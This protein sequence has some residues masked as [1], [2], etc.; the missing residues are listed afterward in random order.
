MAEVLDRR[1]ALE[2]EE[3]VE[4]YG[5]PEEETAFDNLERIIPQEV[6]AE[7]SSHVDLEAF[8]QA[9][10]AR[11]EIAN[12]DPASLAWDKLRKKA[13]LNSKEGQ[14]YRQTVQKESPP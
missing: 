1:A 8:Y 13:E 3:E 5:F 4:Q 9:E 2:L 7:R 12:S 11:A 6:E 14:R 10:L